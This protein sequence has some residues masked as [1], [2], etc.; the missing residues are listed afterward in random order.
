MDN[1]IH[2]TSSPEAQKD[3]HVPLRA[4]M[5]SFWL[6]PNLLTTARLGAVPLIVALFYTDAL[7]AVWARN[8][9]FIL[10]AATDFLD[11]YIARF[12][13]QSSRL[14]Q[15][16]DPLADKLLVAS[17]ILVLTAVG[18]IAG[19]L[20]VPALLIVARDLCVPALRER[21]VELYGAPLKVSNLARFKTATEM[22][23]LASMI[24]G[25]PFGSPLAVW[26]FLIGCVLFATSAILSVLSF[27]LY[28]RQMFSQ[29]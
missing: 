5:R 20:L 18:K 7:W 24:V 29:H 1:A 21:Y 11:G 15:I 26:I 3:L 10:A 13:N 16:L 22:L 8:S 9:L 27:F 28:L 23:A 19:W 25:Q 12:Y 4:T 6:W 14:G 2:M 17:A